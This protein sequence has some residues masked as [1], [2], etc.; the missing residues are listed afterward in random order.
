MNINFL[1]NYYSTVT[2][3]ASSS[4]VKVRKALESTE[5]LLTSLVERS[6]SLLPSSSSYTALQSSS[7]PNL[8][9][10]NGAGG[11]INITD[12][13]ISTG[14]AGERECFNVEQSLIGTGE[15]QPM[16]SEPL[17]ENTEP[18]NPSIDTLSSLGMELGVWSD[19]G[20][21]NILF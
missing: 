4:Q 19:C 1:M 2:M 6:N 3:A 10:A 18:S 16:L 20:I 17:N 8:T 11:D 15:A 12:G 14:G 21:I 5:S 7:A 13:G 9:P